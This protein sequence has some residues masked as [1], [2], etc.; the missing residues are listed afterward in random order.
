MFVSHA[1][2][3]PETLRQTRKIKD[4]DSEGEVRVKRSNLK[5]LSQ[6]DKQK[7]CLYMYIT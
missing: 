7:T 4:K 1:K 2:M 3:V 6:I 5:T